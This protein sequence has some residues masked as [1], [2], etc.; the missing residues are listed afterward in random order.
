MFGVFNANHRED[1]QRATD[2]PFAA[3]WLPECS[4]LKTCM[5]RITEIGNIALQGKT[6]P[7][8]CRG[9]D[10]YEYVVKGRFA[11]RKAMIAE[12]V[13]NRL[14]KLINLPIP[15]FEQ[16]QIDPDLFE[17]GAKRMEM[18]RLGPGVLFGSRR[19]IHVVE[20][21]EADLPQ[22]DGLLKARVLAFDWWIANSDRVFVE[23]VGNPNLLWV[24][25]SQRLVVIDHNLAFDPTLMADFWSEHAFRDSRHRWSESFRRDISDEFRQALGQLQ[26]IWNEMPGD[27]LETNA[28]LSLAQIEALLWKFEREADIFWTSL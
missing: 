1:R 13:A 19:E 26:I 17:Y 4:H 22:I 7:V 20:I 16:L 5:I 14:G 11:G 3:I 21:R 24:E 27:W 25:D 2:V 9:E 23:G 10:G 15:H 28:G 8:F 18:E 6:E 12:W